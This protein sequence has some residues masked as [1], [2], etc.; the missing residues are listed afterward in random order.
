MFGN[1]DD[2][3]RALEIV[4]ENEELVAPEAADQ[5]FIYARDASLAGPQGALQ[6]PADLPQQLV[7]SLVTQSVVDEFEAIEIQKEYG[8][9]QLFPGSYPQQC[10]PEALHERFSIGQ[11][12]QLVLLSRL[13]QRCLHRLARS[14]VRETAQPDAIEHPPQQ[15][16]QNAGGNEAEERT[17][18]CSLESG[19]KH[20]RVDVYAD[21]AD[22]VTACVEDRRK[23]RHER[24]PLVRH[25]LG[26]RRGNTGSVTI[27]QNEHHCRRAMLVNFPDTGLVGNPAHTF[28]TGIG[29]VQHEPNIVTI[30]RERV[31]VV[32][33]WNRATQTTQGLDGANIVGIVQLV[34][35][36]DLILENGVHHRRRRLGQAQQIVTKALVS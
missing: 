25:L 14:D 2:V 36:A 3:T 9:L 27:T 32:D 6:A 30:Q 8:E 23:A 10:L 13:E 21:H 34:G 33:V 18:A 11:A 31:D 16:N 26:G 28:R 1:P 20:T 22:L 29:G 17:V 15:R 12:C 24:A 4:D 19:K 5:H 35:P 7:A